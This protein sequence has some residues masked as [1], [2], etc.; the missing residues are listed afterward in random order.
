M[1]HEIPL[2]YKGFKELEEAK[3]K[4]CLAL[5]NIPDG[6]VVRQEWERRLGN[7]A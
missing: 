1:A 6:N 2:T 4:A 7:Q 5:E 3:T